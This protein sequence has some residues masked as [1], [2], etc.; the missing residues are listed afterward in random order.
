MNRG[1]ADG[2]RSGEARGV[3]P[4]WESGGGSSGVFICNNRMEQN[5]NVVYLCFRG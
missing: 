3:L 2:S 1:L 5:G 4:A